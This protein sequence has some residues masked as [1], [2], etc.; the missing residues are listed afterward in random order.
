[1]YKSLITLVLTLIY[2]NCHSQIPQGI[3]YQGVATDRHGNALTEQDISLRITILNSSPQGDIDYSETHLIKTNTFGL[4]NVVIG[5]GVSEVNSFENISWTN[6]EKFLQ[7]EIDIRGGSS[8][9]LLGVTQFLTVPFAFYAL[10]TADSLAAGEGINLENGYIINSSPD[11]EISLIGTGGTEISGEYPEF[12]IF[13]P[14]AVEI[15]DTSSTNEL[16][17]LSFEDNTL[18]ISNG[19][20]IKFTN[21]PPWYLNQETNDV[22][23]DNNNVAIGTNTSDY[24]LSIEGN[25]TG[26]ADDRTLLNLRNSSTDFGSMARI[27]M[28]AGASGNHLRLLHISSS[29]AQSRYSDFGQVVSNG[30]G[31]VLGAFNSSGIIKFETGSDGEFPYE[32]MRIDNT[33]NVGIGTEQPKAKLEVTDGDVYINDVNKGI[34]LKSPNGNCFRVT[35]DNNGEFVKTQIACP[36]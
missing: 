29:Y 2:F 33:G 27:T 32:R 12:T 9:Q 6:N 14:E 10:K 30:S 31:L 34:I 4:F 3:S 8:Y 26:L 19:N 21:T 28:R 35:I 1:M 36:N 20:S 11:Q 18:S 15:A 13:T 22:Y 17:E 23:V 5:Q 7:I 24:L 16:Q 25:T